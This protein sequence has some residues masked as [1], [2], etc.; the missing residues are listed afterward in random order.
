MV[1]FFRRKKKKEETLAEKKVAELSRALPSIQHQPRE[2]PQPLREKPNEK[3]VSKLDLLETKIE[4]LKAKVDIIVS[5][6]E[7]LERIIKN[8]I[9][10]S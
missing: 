6:I 2:T 9:E 8:A 4:T 5:K 10:E 3:L 1:F 7:E